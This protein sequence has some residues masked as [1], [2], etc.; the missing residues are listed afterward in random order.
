[1]EAQRKNID[2]Y[3]SVTDRIYQPMLVSNTA[4]P[5]AM[6]FT[7]QRFGLT[8]SR[9]GMFEYVSK[10][11]RYSLHDTYVTSCFP[12][13]QIFFGS[14]HKLYFHISSSFIT[15][16]RPFLISSCPCR[17]ISAI[18]GEDMRYSVSSIA[19]FWAVSFLRYL[20]AFFIRPS[21]S[22]IILSSRNNS[23][24]SSIAVITRC[25]NPLQS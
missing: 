23:A 15:R 7:L 17:I 1:M 6:L 3:H 12:I 13:C 18:A 22:A 4:A 9:E 24:F 11:L 8:N 20:T 2:I 19:F 16:P 14:G 25:F 21:S 10:Q 5:Q